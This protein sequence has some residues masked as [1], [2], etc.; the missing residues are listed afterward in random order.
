MSDEKLKIG[1]VVEVISDSSW[2]GTVYEITELRG[3]RQIRGHL[4][5]IPPTASTHK[6]IGDLTMFYRESVRL[7]FKVGDIVEVSCQNMASY[8][9]LH[10]SINK[11]YYA[12]VPN[13]ADVTVTALNGNKIYREGRNLCFYVKD[14]KRIDGLKPSKGVKIFSDKGWGPV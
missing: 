10:V 1:D 14:L 6:K 8:N 13:T 12:A 7:A 2:K 3:E 9:G 11:F 4:I 5:R